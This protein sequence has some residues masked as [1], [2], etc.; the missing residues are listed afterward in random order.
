M[1]FF[2]GGY[3]FW[4]ALYI[5]QTMYLPIFVLKVLKIFWGASEMGDTLP[6]GATVRTPGPYSSFD[7]CIQAWTTDSNC[8]YLLQC[9]VLRI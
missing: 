1:K 3:F 9:S 7:H 4:R 5:V 8:R 2:L 6:R